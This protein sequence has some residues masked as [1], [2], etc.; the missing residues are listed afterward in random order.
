METPSQRWGSRCDL[1]CAGWI[2]TSDIGN[3]IAEPFRIEFRI[4]VHV[5]LPLPSSAIEPRGIGFIRKEL[6]VAVARLRVPP[7]AQE[8]QGSMQTRKIDPIADIPGLR[9]R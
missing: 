7:L 4:E 9:K 1:R 8:G 3:P 5:A 2:R 6:N